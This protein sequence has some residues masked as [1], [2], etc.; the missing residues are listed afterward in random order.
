MRRVASI[1]VGG[2]DEQKTPSSALRR[3]G[4]A[5]V[6][7]VVAFIL[8]YALGPALHDKAPFI[9]FVPAVIIAGIAGGFGPS[10]IASLVSTIL[11]SRFIT[12]SDTLPRNLNGVMAGVAYIFSAL[13]VASLTSVIRRQMAE[14]QHEVNDR[15]IIQGRLQ[16]SEQ[17]FRKIFESAAV[18]LVQIDATGKCVNA[19]PKLCQITGYSIEELLTLNLRDITFAEDR[20][21]DALLLRKGFDGGLPNYQNQKRLVRRTG[22]VI[23]VRTTTSFLHDPQGK[24]ELPI[25]IVEDITDHKAAEE[26]L[27]KS[28]AKLRDIVD[29]SPAMIFVKDH[30]GH[31]L[32]SNTEFERITHKPTKEIVGKTDHEIFS[33][34]QADAFRV[35]DLRVWETGHAYE[36]EETA[37]HDDG[38]HISIVHKFPLRDHTGQIYATG[39]IVTDITQRKR[40]EEELRKLQKGYADLVSTIDGIVWEAIP[41]TLKFSFVSQQAERL[42]LYPIERWLTESNFW[43]N[44]L[45]PDDR[46]WAVEFCRQA[47]QARRHHDFE[48]RM[49]AADGR[50]IWLRDIVNVTAAPDGTVKLRGVMIDISEQKKAQEELRR[51]E[52]LLRMTTSAAKADLWSWD[53]VKDLLECPSIHEPFG[54]KGPIKLSIYLEHVKEEDREPLMAEVRDCMRNNREFNFEFRVVFPDGS[55]GWRHSRG[56]PQYIGGKAVRFSGMSIDVTARK[57]AEESLRQSE[58]RLRMMTEGARIGLWDRD[59]RE[60]SIHWNSIE[61]QQFDLSP[62]TPVDFDVFI[63]HVHSEDRSRVATEIQRCLEQNKPLDTEFR[64]L[65]RDGTI[66]WNH[67]KGAPIYSHGQPW[68]FSGMSMDITERKNA[69]QARD[70]ARNALALHAAQLEDHVA[71][72]TLEL[73]QSL[74]DMETFCYTI[75]HDLSAPLRYMRGFSLALL[76]DHSGQLDE[77]ARV[78]CERIHESAI[79]MEQLI[80][81][82][83]AFGR[84]SHRDL[85]TTPVDLIEEIEKVLAQSTPE[86]EERHAEIVLDR[87]LSKVSADAPVLDHVLQNLISNAMK[88]VPP[89]RRPHVHIYAETRGNRVRVWVEDNGIGIAPEHQQRIFSPFERLH[90]KED[91]PGTGMGLAIVQRGIEKMGGHVGVESQVGEGSRFWIELPAPRRAG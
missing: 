63:N 7:V 84:L 62:E 76:E 20:A 61:Y 85:P 48:Y 40:A 65:H 3:Y 28:Q 8:R 55:I 23:W 44:H 43:Q 46:D 50:A 53:I 26:A 71:Q 4:I 51:S 72:R 83:L 80:S 1:L 86:I 25:S 81:D 18:G 66:R 22:E 59:M 41:E 54:F 38:Q 79:R 89:H 58:E 69:E 45:H 36:F 35:N 74:R 15:K 6:A 78:Y 91:Y 87:S 32:L 19:N 9:F 67:S 13:V 5:L 90:T 77:N 14:L 34:A 39:G 68:R 21:T 49:I 2:V 47:T 29:H 52:E 75:A 11:A 27:L 60:N 56:R 70:E 64:I 57:Q 24:P 33:P 82:L 16:Q 30:S 37:V 42:L 17:R 12:S 88:F 73:K 31:Y 10:L